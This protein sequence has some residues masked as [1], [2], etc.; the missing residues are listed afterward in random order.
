MDKVV[1]NKE[2]ESLG[3]PSF[4]EIRR[5]ACASIACLSEEER[6]MLW[7]QLNRGVDLLYSHELMCQYLWSF[8]INHEIRMHKAFEALYKDKDAFK[9][10]FAIVDWGCGQGLATV[11]FFDFLKSCRP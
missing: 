1:Y 11:C 4:G 8:G 6:T 9:E 3:N 5:I 7:N 10:N 2:I